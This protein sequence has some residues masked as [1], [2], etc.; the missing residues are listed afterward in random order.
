MW[1]VMG[2]WAGPDHMYVGPQSRR[3]T[4]IDIARKC[5]GYMTWK[6]LN[7]GRPAHQR[8]RVVPGVFTYPAKPKAGKQ[9]R[10]K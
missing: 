4:A 9:R 8:L 1:A 3:D 6:D 7:K 10:S 2:G 5:N